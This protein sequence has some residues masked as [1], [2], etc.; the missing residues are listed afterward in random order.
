MVS[1]IGDTFESCTWPSMNLKRDGI[2]DFYFYFYFFF[3]EKGKNLK[4]SMK[5]KKKKKINAPNTKQPI[6]KTLN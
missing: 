6:E 2:V 3:T 1:V 5:K 4:K